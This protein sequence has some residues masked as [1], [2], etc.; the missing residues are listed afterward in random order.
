MSRKPEYDT[1]VQRYLQASIDAVKA[2]RTIY[3][4]ANFTEAE[5]LSNVSG[6]YL[7]FFYNANGKLFTY[8]GESDNVYKRWKQHRYGIQ[9]LKKT[10]YN[11]FR[12][13]LGTNDIS[14]I[15]FVLLER[16]LDDQSA[17]LYRE[18]YNIYKFKSRN[19]SLNSKNC[20]SRLRCPDGTH[21]RCRTWLSYKVVDE[22]VVLLVFGKSINKNCNLTFVIK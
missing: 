22:K 4:D 8:I 6:V 5:V 17:R 20:S 16:D 12:R 11:K 10:L 21:G 18:T 7:I 2:V 1:Q 14:N 19:Y 13:H 9:S 15:A 3:T